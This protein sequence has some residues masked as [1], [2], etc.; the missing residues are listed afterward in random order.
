MYLILS[1]LMFSLSI[2]SKRLKQVFWNG[3]PD[4]GELLGGLLKINIAW[5]MAQTTN[6]HL[7]HLSHGNYQWGM[8]ILVALLLACG[9]FALVAWASAILRGRRIASFLG[10]MVWIF[11]IRLESINGIE[12]YEAPAVMFFLLCA[13]NDVLVYLRLRIDNGS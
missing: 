12:T 5:I 11:L 13:I 9:G 3:R 4:T 2:L 8:P 6:S 7:Y 1:F 10:V